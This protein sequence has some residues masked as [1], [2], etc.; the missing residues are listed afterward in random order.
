MNGVGVDG[1]PRRCVITKESAGHT[2]EQY[3]LLHECPGNLLSLNA[4]V[5]SLSREVD[6][7]NT[8]M[9]TPP[10]W[11]RWKRCQSLVSGLSSSLQPPQPSP[12][13]CSSHTPQCPPLAASRL[14]FLV[15]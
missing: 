10:V 3:Y 1:Y 8:P 5:Q 13:R 4:S 11:S 12:V 14:A 2:K 6:E 15:P 9:M 7:P